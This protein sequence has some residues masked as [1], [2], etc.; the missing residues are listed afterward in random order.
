MQV[1][2]FLFWLISVSWLIVLPLAAQDQGDSLTAD[3][4]K[5]L[6]GA[7]EHRAE[8][9]EALKSANAAEQK[10]LQFLIAYQPERDQGKITGARLLEEVRLALRVRTETEWQRQIPEDLFLNDVLPYANLDEPRDSWRA[11]FY[12]KFWP[13]VK[14]AKS[15]TE[16]A[17]ILN[18]KIFGILNV[19]YSTGRKRANQSPKE[20]I[21]QGLASCSGLSIILVD[22]C[23]AVGVPARIAGIPK[24]NNKQGNHTWVEVWDGGWHFTGAC[25]YNSEG[26][27]RAWFNADAAQADPSSELSSIYALSYKP[28]GQHFPMVWA[29]RDKSLHAVNVTT[30]YLAEK[31]PVD[32]SKVRFL[33]RLWDVSKSKR[34]K[35]KL[36]VVAADDS[37]DK[38][39]D[40]SRDE[41]FDTNDIASFDLRRGESYT[42]T[43]EHD[44]Q[45]TDFPFQADNAAQQAVE[46]T[47]PEFH[48]VQPDAAQLNAEQIAQLKAFATTV[49]TAD[50]K[51]RE[52]MKTPAE[53]D[54]LLADN[55]DQV[56][57]AVWQAYLE[58]ARSTEL[59]KADFV[60]NQVT[61]NDHKSPYVVR[62]VGERPAG[63]WPLVIAMHGGGGAPAEVN[64]SQWR[65]MQKYYRD[66]PEVMGYK[67]L[68]LR[69]PNN[70]WNGFYDDYVYPL[71]EN[72]IAQFLVYGDV[73]PNKV[74]IM[75][76]SHGGYGAFSIGPKIP[77]RF[78]AIHSSAA[79][80]SDGQTSTK[81]LRTTRMTFMIGEKD[82]AYGRCERCKTYAKQ[83]AD[84]RQGRIDI[85]P[86]EMLFK[87]G[88]GHGGLP[89]RDLLT[90]ILP[91]NRN[92]VPREISWELTDG[93]V[94]DFFWLRVAQ[95][96]AGQTI[97]ARIRRNQ[98][99]LETSKTDT[100]TL[101][102]DER[103][104]DLAN[105]VSVSVNGASTSIKL[106]P[107]LTTLCETMQHRRDPNLACSV[108]LPIEA[109][110]KQ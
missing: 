109:K 59:A 97:E 80:P 26:L 17:Q 88:Q 65:V 42:L 31:K 71:I 25:E 95:P 11:D 12:E 61:F 62:E 55:P 64:D 86:V 58:W 9:E 4:A 47:I 24:W 45:R 63:G 92:P 93:V 7:G 37:A 83:L 39:E 75:G 20:S 69:A 16:A 107:S 91:Y 78:A 103:L 85:Y 27:N 30:R 96:A 28:T 72:L 14:D 89:D 67:Y 50:E 19:K 51:S 79:A 102:L 60:A 94:K 108:Q 29:L 36:T 38:H 52:T 81:T 82:N 100:L 35:A 53:L 5:R 104:V 21:E 99:S 44:G 66:H 46:L 23:R 90:R 43:V 15:A 3:L 106:S 98:I 6:E 2:L 48:R 32:E 54:R 8:L 76:Y 84:L 10:P 57:A 74:F 13:L 41:S 56:R 40:F 70:T 73:D 87:A 18:S 22:A 33:L 105:E 101:L 77:Y 34:I 110:A 68:A 49:F 1:R